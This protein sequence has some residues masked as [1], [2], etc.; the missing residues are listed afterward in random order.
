[1]CSSL[2][3]Q[4][5]IE[6]AKANY[7]SVLP[8]SG[9][10]RKS[11]WFCVVA[12]RLNAK[13]IVVWL[14]YGNQSCYRT[15]PMLLI[16]AGKTWYIRYL[17]RGP[18]QEVSWTSGWRLIVMICMAKSPFPSISSWISATGFIALLLLQRRLCESGT[19]WTFRFDPLIERASAAYRLLPPRWWP[20]RLLWLIVLNWGTDWP[21]GNLQYQFSRV[22]S[23][24]DEGLLAAVPG[25][26]TAPGC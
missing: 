6:T 8:T 22:K 12:A 23:D 21:S 11:R 3:R 16:I 24:T 13:I 5:V 20:R 17:K 19:D 15:V 1:M 10:S 26:K 4:L 9:M 7:S 14:G 25:K 18:L 2:L